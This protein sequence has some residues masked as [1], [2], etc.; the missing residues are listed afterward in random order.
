MMSRGMNM[1]YASRECVILQQITT[2]NN[3]LRNAA[4][5]TPNLHGK[6]LSFKVPLHHQSFKIILTSQS[7]AIQR[8]YG[9][10]QT[11]LPT[12]DLRH[13]G[14]EDK[15]PTKQEAI[16]MSREVYRLQ[17]GESLKVKRNSLWTAVSSSNVAGY[18]AI[19]GFKLWDWVL[20]WPTYTAEKKQQVY[21]EYCS[22]ELNVYLRNKDP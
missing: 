21:D 3:F 19:K 12:K 14:L 10:P 9:L 6:V 17:K 1:S 8:E 18:S 5:I 13:F 2:K 15:N 22:H 20:Q 4:T 7:F 16:T 11:K